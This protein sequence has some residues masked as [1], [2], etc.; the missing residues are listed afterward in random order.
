MA[1]AV[2]VAPPRGLGIVRTVR[3]ITET[4]ET[5]TTADLITDTEV[6]ARLLLVLLLLPGSR[7]PVLKHTADM[8][9]TEAT[10]LPPVLLLEWGYHP[11][12]LHL[13]HPELLVSLAA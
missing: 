3:T 7:P 10:V 4:G 9:D 8:V 2:V 6:L 12:P 1:A 11:L 13:E 5:R